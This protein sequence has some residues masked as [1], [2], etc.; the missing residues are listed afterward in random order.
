M[1]SV[2]SLRLNG[3]TLLIIETDSD[4]HCLY[5]SITASYAQF[6]IT[7]EPVHVILHA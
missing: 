7:I 2:Q 1:D 5:L 4:N 3:A 6:I